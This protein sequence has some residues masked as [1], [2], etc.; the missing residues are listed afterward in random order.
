[1]IEAIVATIFLSKAGLKGCQ[2]SIENGRRLK[3]K[4]VTLQH[5]SGKQVEDH[6]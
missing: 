3:D 5:L 1:L 6:S 2:P 4:K